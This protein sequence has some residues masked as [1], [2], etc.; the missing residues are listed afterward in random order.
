MA[1][2]VLPHHRPHDQ[3]RTEPAKQKDHTDK[4]VS[5]FSTGEGTVDFTFRNPVLQKSADHFKVGIDELT[6]NLG[7]L[8]MLEYGIND[9]LFRVIRNGDAGAAHATW[10]MPDGTAAEGLSKWRDAF[11]FKVDR[12]Y[13]TFQEVVNRFY[14]VG[15]AVGTY[16]RTRE[17]VHNAGAGYNP[18]VNFAAPYLDADPSLIDTQRAHTYFSINITPNGQLFFTGSSVFWANF[19]I[20]VPLEKYRQILFKD[21]LK[22]FISLEPDTGA[23]RQAFYRN[24]AGNLVADAFVSWDG[25]M[26]PGNELVYV[27]DGNLLHT[28][29]R[30]VTLEVGCSLP[31][32]NSPLVDHGQEAPD[33]V[34]GRFMFHKP[35]TLQQETLPS[36]IGVAKVTSES[37]GV[38]TL[39]GPRDRVVFHHLKP[40]QKL[41]TL[42]LKLWARVRTYATATKKWGMQT[43]ECPVDA[44][45]YWHI[46]LH[47]VPK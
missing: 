40:Q 43:I 12:V 47:F 26:V 7:G 32:K 41:Q 11:E 37:L 22:E 28:L 39:Q 17:L 3:L 46:R 15:N 23:A 35:Y 14:E 45:D 4:Y 31:I 18:A 33:F 44:S 34:L 20:Q 13:N 10:A 30:R 16:I 36:G 21:P 38:Q 8:S 6:V 9:V 42:R 2:E 29:D 1:H 5:C 24:G 25:T 19:V 27:G